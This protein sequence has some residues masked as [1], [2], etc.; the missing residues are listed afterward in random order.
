MSVDTILEDVDSADVDAS[1]TEVARSAMWCQWDGHQRRRQVFDRLRAYAKGK[2]GIPDVEEGASAELVE[3][4]SLSVINM[5]GVVLDSFD[6]GLSVVGFRS[7]SADDDEP[8]WALWQASGMDARQSEAHRAALTYGHAFV[9][10][11]PEDMDGGR[12]RMAVWSPRH[13]V[14]DFDDPRRDLFPRSAMLMRKVVD[15]E[16]GRGWSV[17]LVDDVTVTPGF[18]SKRRKGSAK[19]ADVEVTGD[20]WEHGATYDGAAVC[21]VVAFVNK[22]SADDDDDEGGEVDP[23]IRKQRALNGVNFDRLVNSR[24][25]AFQQMVIIGWAGSKSDVMK[26]S[27]SRALAFPDHPDDVSVQKLSA[28]PLAP[29]NDLIKEM[30]EEFALEAAIPLYTATGSISN[31]STDTAAMVEKAHQRKLARKKASFGESWELVLRLAVVM[32]GGEQPD[33]AAEVVWDQTEA[34]S[35]AQVVDGIVKLASIPEGSAGVPVE[36]MLDML[37]GMTQQRI[38]AVRD[39]IRRRRS[40]SMLTGLL[41]QSPA[42]AQA[43]DAPVV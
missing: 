18:I 29:Y 31:V 43:P 2:A 42:A 33:D 3:L 21:P 24:F 8:A 32:D 34:R 13:A 30:K 5:I 1:L 27:A 41:G 11:L 6:A 39:G 20:P 22:R 16:R 19:G 26:T 40:S 37:P 12:P 17:L 4:A 9:S 38:D 10:V 7:P 28:S 35:F 15:P 14:V 25:N 36:E 23:L